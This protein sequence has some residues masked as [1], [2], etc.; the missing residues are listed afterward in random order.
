[1]SKCVEYREYTIS[2]TPLQLSGK[3]EWRSKIEISSQ[4]EGIVAVESYADDTIHATE[5]SADTHGIQLG[6]DVIDGNAP[7]FGRLRRDFQRLRT[8]NSPNRTRVFPPVW[9]FYSAVE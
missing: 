7:A 8:I 3:N 9:R 2:S 6:Q 1:M 4:R 5:E